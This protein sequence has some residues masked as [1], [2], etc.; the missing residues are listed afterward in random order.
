MIAEVLGFY[1]DLS[2]LPETGRDIPVQG[3]EADRRPSLFAAVPN[4]PFKI[5]HY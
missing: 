3:T 2:Y 5:V 4:F 1:F